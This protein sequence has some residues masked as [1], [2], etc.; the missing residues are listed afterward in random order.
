MVKESSIK[1]AKLLAAKRE[2]DSIKFSLKRSTLPLRDRS[3]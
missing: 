3:E 2:G 1:D